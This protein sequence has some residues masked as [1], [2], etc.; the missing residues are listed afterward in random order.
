MLEHSNIAKVYGIFSDM[1]NFYIISEYLSENFQ[2]TSF[3]DEAPIMINQIL[4]AALYL[5]KIDINLG[6][7]L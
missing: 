5:K 4:E 2:N 7:H 1:D 6:F 3:I